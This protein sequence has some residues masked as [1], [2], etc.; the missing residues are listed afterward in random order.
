M[1]NLWRSKQFFDGEVQDLAQIPP[2][3][4]RLGVSLRVI[5]EQRPSLKQRETRS[6]DSY[7]GA[8]TT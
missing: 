5:P 6:K 2:L 8:K 4:D 3:D 1:C 7:Q